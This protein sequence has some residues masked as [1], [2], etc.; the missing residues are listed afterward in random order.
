MKSDSFFDESSTAPPCIRTGTHRGLL[1]QSAKCRPH[2]PPAVAKHSG[3]VGESKS[4]GLRVP[5]I[6]SYPATEHVQ[7]KSTT[8]HRMEIAHRIHT[9][10]Q[11]TG[12]TGRSQR[13]LHGTWI[14]GQSGK[15]RERVQRNRMGSRPPV[16]KTKQ[17]VV[18]AAALYLKNHSYGEYIFDWGWANAAKMQAF[19]TTPSSCVPCPSHPPPAADCCAWTRPSKS[20]SWMGCMGSCKP[21]MRSPFT[22]CSPPRRNTI[23]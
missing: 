4:G 14:F 17:P 22:F 20:T 16:G 13:S 10:M 15:Q 18:G 21:Q 7:A 11:M 9:S 6:P 5:S 2:V 8:R 23:V 19:P 12:M 1:T 3:V